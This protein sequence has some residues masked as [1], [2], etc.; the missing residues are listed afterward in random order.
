VNYFFLVKNDLPRSNLTLVVAATPVKALHFL[1]LSLILAATPA[2]VQN[3]VW[4]GPNESNWGVG[5]NWNTGTVP[6]AANVFIQNGDN[7][8]LVNDN[9]GA[10]PAQPHGGAA[11]R[12]RFPNNLG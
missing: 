11:A 12:A 8:P 5:A 1:L 7:G 10:A 6:T 9:R 4:T 2:F 3:A